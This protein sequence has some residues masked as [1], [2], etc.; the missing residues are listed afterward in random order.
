MGGASWT[1][2]LPLAAALHSL[3]N[4]HRAQHSMAQATD[5]PSV[6]AV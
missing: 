5:S 4:L 2:S 3:T 1:P 6:K